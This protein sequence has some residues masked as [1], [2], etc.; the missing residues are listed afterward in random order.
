ML[1]QKKREGGRNKKSHLKKKSCISPR[2]HIQFI[3]RERARS[4][5]NRTNAALREYVRQKH[6]GRSTH[7]VR[8][9]LRIPFYQNMCA[10]THS[11]TKFL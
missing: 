10:H 6:I 2:D 8:K 4:S 1:L 9:Y 3:K 7:I 11:V 5:K